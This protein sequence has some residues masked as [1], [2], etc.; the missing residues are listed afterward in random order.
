MD[1]AICHCFRLKVQHW[2]FEEIIVPS[3]QSLV[4]I[5]YRAH[6]YSLYDS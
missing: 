5:G 6:R 4:S 3:F 2:T 1:Y